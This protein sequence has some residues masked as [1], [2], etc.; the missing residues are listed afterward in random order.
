MPIYIA[1]SLAGDTAIRISSSTC[2][3]TDK[4]SSSLLICP[5]NLPLIV[6]KAFRASSFSP[7]TVDL[8]V[9]Y[10][11]SH[12]ST[13][14]HLFTIPFDKGIMSKGFQHTHQ[15]ICV[16]SQEP[17][18]YFPSFTEDPFIASDTH[19]IDQIVG[20]T[21]RYSF[22]LFETLTLLLPLKLR[23]H[24]FSKRQLKSTWTAAPAVASRRMFSE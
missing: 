16:C 7:S 8:S 18:R 22:R 13:R 11:V 6:I 19:C 15:S 5:P 9:F 23:R 3:S 24:T 10:E 17:R 4:G 14:N 2:P 1:A 20:Q 21:K 12:Q